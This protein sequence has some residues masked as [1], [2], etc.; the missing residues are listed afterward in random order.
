MEIS[1]VALIG[2]SKSPYNVVIKLEALMNISPFL[3]V[4]LTCEITLP[5][6]SH[7]LLKAGLRSVQT[8]D[9]HTARAALHDCDCPHHGTD[10]CDCQMVVLLVY[11]KMDEPATL[12]LHGND[13]TT[14][15]SIT[16]SAKSN[17]DLD[18]QIRQ[19]L[20]ISATTSAT[21]NA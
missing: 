21:A 16:A 3:T 1:E 13:G 6:V 12:I 9:L 10:Q 15:L 18:E 7:Q 11:G 5:W 17:R 4:N 2:C 8:F 14:W 19:S 20:G